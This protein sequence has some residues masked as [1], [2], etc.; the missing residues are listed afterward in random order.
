[1]STICAEGWPRIEGPPGLRNHVVVLST[2]ALTDRVTRLAAPD[3][4]LCLTPGWERGLRSEDAALQ[5][6]ALRA[7]AAHPNVAAILCVTHDRA[8]AERLADELAGI[9]KPAATTALMAES[10]YD[11]AALAI[12]EAARSLLRAA[13]S[14]APVKLAAADLTVALECGGS[15]ASSALCS[16]P[17]IGRFVDRLIAEGGIAIVSETAEFLGAEEVV[18]G[19]CQSP[20]I[21]DAI[22]ARLAAE[23]ALMHGEG[24]DYRGVNPTEENI[25]AG[26]TTL[27]EKTM[28]AVCKIGT[29]RFAGCLEFGE[30]PSGPG[31]HF[32]DTPFFSPTSLSGMVLGGAQVALFAMGVFN[33]SGIPLAPVVKVC[34]NPVTLRCWD[35]EID[36]D[37]SGVIEGSTSLH[38]A[39][40]LIAARLVDPS[41][42]AS[43]RRGEGQLMLPRRMS[44]L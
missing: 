41:P 23:E 37:V 21:A 12:A 36:V 14:A 25:E 16:N 8:A 22:L 40:D 9:G 5:E 28:G 20:G 44:A 7:L 39:A 38:Q 26:L 6:R 34:G 10:G 2:V 13:S 31:L 19:R 33:P 24:I 18:R 35:K 29:S 32:M 27:T 30:A 1:M 11:E 17:A 3:G 4:T 15:D 42:T 43:E